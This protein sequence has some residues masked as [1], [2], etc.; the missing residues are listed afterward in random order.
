V[1]ATYGGASASASLSVTRPTV[2]TASF[3]VTGPT[4]TDTCTLT[5]NGDTLNCTFNGSTSTAPGNIVAYDWSYRVATT[6]TQT[7][8]GP[9][10]TSPAVTCSWL[11]AAPLPA[12]SNQWLPLTVTLKVHDDLGNVSA[13]ATNTGARLF[14]QGACGY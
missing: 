3:G 2:A 14:P 13:E 6:L 5:N 10:L 11:P 12:G 8:S 4:E 9:V 7:T 1:T